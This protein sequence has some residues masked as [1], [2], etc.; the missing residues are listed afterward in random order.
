MA[1]DAASAFGPPACAMSGRPPP[2]PPPSAADPA[3][4]RSTA[5]CRSARSAVTAT[6]IEA[7]PPSVATRQI[8]PLVRFALIS[9][10]IDFNSRAGVSSSRRPMKLTPFTT[11]A[12]S[13][14]PPPPAASLR[15][16]AD[17]SR[18]A[19]RLSSI[20]RATRSASCSGATFS[21]SAACCSAAS[22]LSSQSSAPDSV[23]ASI[24]RTPP[25]TADSEIIFSRLI[26]PVR[27]TCVP[28]HNSTD[29]APRPAI[30]VAPPICTTR[31]SSPYFSPN[32]ASAPSSMAAS[33]V[34]MRVD[35]SLFM[36]MR[37]LTMSATADN[38]SA[39]TARGCEK[40]KRSLSGAT[41]EPFCAT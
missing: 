27:F 6:T 2:P 25:A 4:T 10:A 18:S 5:F 19:F 20:R 1:A 37:S 17:I 33:G 40:S 11:T 35:T 21:M 8:T 14:A 31:T 15:R 36:R 9:S 34:M 29:Q 26:S 28:P 22:R 38:S 13:P 32:K 41:S 39:L 7:L 30:S 3:R 23:T 24:R 12:P 16:N